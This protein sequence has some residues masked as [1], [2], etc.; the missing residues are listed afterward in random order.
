MKEYKT[1]QIR[2]IALAGHGASG[3]T[4]LAEAF[5][6]SMGEVN[7]IG[8]IEAG[9]TVS[10]Y[11][12]DEIERQISISS[13]IL[14]GDWKDCKINILDTP[15]Y[16][17]FV[18][19]VLG[20]IQVVD[21]V[22]L[23]M[24]AL[25]GIEVGTEQG[26][27]F[28]R[29]NGVPRIFVVNKLDKEHA[30]YENTLKS[31]KNRYGAGVVAAQFPVDEGKPGYNS[32]V[33]IVLM[34]KIT[35]ATD[36]SG[37]MTLED[38]PSDLQSVAEELRE[39]LIEAVAES[40]DELL[41]YYLENGELTTD[42]F[43]KGFRKSIA[44]QNLFPVFCTSSINNIGIQRLLDVISDYLPNPLETGTI[45]GLESSDGKEIK[46]KIDS[47]GPVISYILKTISEQHLGELSFFKVFS[48]QIKNGIDLLNVSNNVVERIGQV[49]FMN[50]KTRNETGYVVAGDIG[51]VVKLKS[52]HT[53][54]TLCE[55]GQHFIISPIKLPKPVMLVAVIPK[56]RSDE[57]KISVGL[58]RLHE[59]DPSF[60][61][62]HDAELSQL[63]VSGQGELHLDIIIKRLKDKFGVEVK[64]EQPKV[65]YRESIRG[66]TTIKYRHK[67]QSGGAGQFG[68]VKFFIQPYNEKHPLTIPSDY[69]IRGEDL[70]EL[71][72]GGKLHF[73]NG[74]VGGVIDA[75]FIQAV[76]KGIL[77][78][79]QNGIISG[80]PVRDVQVILYDGMMHSVDS[81]EAAFKTAGRMAFKNG[82]LEA[83]P[84]L[85]EPIYD[86]V[87]H[88]PEDY[89]G[90]V[91]GDLS[92]RRGKIQGID[93]DGSFQVIRAKVPLAELYRY[94]TK[95]RSMT[96]GRGIHEQDFSHYEETP[97]EIAQKIVE[98]A[99]E[100]N[101]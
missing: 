6:F 40:D 74:I 75:R 96:A 95:I 27:R 97:K 50:G 53:G 17:D 47:N 35:F 37:K 82:F 32:I 83:N 30:N 86:V 23:V 84:V 2:N 61:I 91:M 43:E 18:G 72:W 60:T 13:S 81:N 36:R 85:Y 10:D 14:H 1:E 5:L 70:D 65:P 49:Y 57:E 63:V 64:T 99:K 9:T 71:P 68:E 7:R 54:N 44:D 59:E 93:S 34:K 55:K 21:T 15:G 11:N 19:E 77:E 94:S 90:D 45:K 41:E 52:T 76:K 62:K 58:N 88:V 67:K 33:D 26:W 79:M 24:Q 20:A 25:S 89:M 42:Q 4:S 100:E 46:Q 51:A 92:S 12:P 22:I 56:S 73:I 101:K 16:S 69:T 38:I 98:A 48:G 80:C 87:I 29:D 8:N 3:K 78:M 28:A 31:V 39:K 66:K